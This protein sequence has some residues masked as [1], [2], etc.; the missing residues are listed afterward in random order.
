[1]TSKVVTLSGS[2]K[3]Y[4]PSVS[5]VN[6]A[7]NETGSKS[8]EWLIKMDDD[9]TGSVAGYEQYS[10]L[11]GWYANSSRYTSPDVSNRLF[12]SAKLR[13]SDLVIQIPNGG[14]G[15]T[16]EN[17]MNSGVPYVSIEIVR[18]GNIKST[19]VKLQETKFSTCYIKEY[20]QE[21]DRIV[22][23]ARITKKENTVFVY[24]N[25]G[26]NTGQTVSS[27]DYSKNT[28]S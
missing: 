12:T 23:T 4:L 6:D 17:K 16:V 26:N 22:L 5:D 18:L 10:E 19:S 1:M 28:V 7:N 20:T 21:L 9:L 14:Y 8:P 11:F 3:F 15:P 25:D 2:K 27:T 13:H 24:D